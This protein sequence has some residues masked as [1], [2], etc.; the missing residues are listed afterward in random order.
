MPHTSR[1]R[2]K[3]SGLP[4]GTPVY[5]GERK[6]ERTQIAAI[7]FNEEHV[8]EKAVQNVEE[9]SALK[10]QAGLLW[11]NLDGLTDV[12]LL[13]SIG[14][15]F[16]LH[17]L[18]LE[19]IVNTEQRPK[20]EDYG[21][22]AYIV[23]KQLMYDAAAKQV[24]EEQIS[25][26]VGSDFLLSFG[27]REGDVFDPVRERIRFGKGRIRRM[28]PDYLGYSLLDAVV[29]NYFVVLEYFGEQIEDLEDRILD[30]ATQT[31]MHDVYRLRRELLNLRRAVWPLREVIAALE[32]GE[33]PLFQSETA[34]YLRDVYDHTVQM[35]DT[36][37]SY[38]DI[39]TSMLDVYLS[40]VSYRM[41][42]VMKV[43]TVI[44]TIFLPLTFLAG[45]WGMNFKHMPETKWIWGYPLALAL[46]FGIGAWMLWFFKKRKWM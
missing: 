29:D 26:V 6:H 22:H 30:K 46:M 41:N 43:L 39:L 9:L 2:S 34:V 10:G 12:P 4:P 42:V 38:R 19:D 31:L 21:S 20:F 37:E 16:E 17:P 45:V 35:M 32:R 36:I 27:E 5:V 40:A 44:S 13:E 24:I 18:V 33:T 25:V 14:K 28:G 3:K 15:L 1:K 23:L 7:L 8:A 11:V